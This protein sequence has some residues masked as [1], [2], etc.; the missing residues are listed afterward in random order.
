MKPGMPSTSPKVAVPTMVISVGGVLGEDA[1]GVAEGPALVVHG[2]LV[3]DDLVR[4]PRARGRP[5]RANGLSRSSSIQLTPIVPPRPSPVSARAVGVDQLGEALDR[6]GGGVDAV[7]GLDAGRRADASTRSWTSMPPSPSTPVVR[8]TT[9]SMPSLDVAKS[10]SKVFPMVSVRI[11]VPA[12]KATPRTTARPVSTKRT[13]WAQRPL[14]VRLNMAIY[15]PKLFMRSRTDSA[16]GCVE[17]VDDVAVGEEDDPVGVGRRHGVVGD[18]HDRLAELPHGLAHEGEDLGA[19]AAVEVAGGLVGEDDLRAAGEGA[20]HGHALLLATGELAG[21]VLEAVAEPDG[22]DTTRSS[23]ARSG[24]RPARSIGSVMFS[25]AVSV[26]TRL[27]AWNTKPRR[28]R[29]SFVSFLSFRRGEV[30]V[31][32]EHL[33][34][35]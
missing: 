16:V 10:P 1:D 30:D 32:D 11:I 24:L 19:G 29:R 26:G 31:A 13:L 18:H 2:G 4:R 34:R 7:D 5:T 27:N 15:L 8:C 21:P 9:T 28:S 12:M 17:L 25:R 35:R 3:E 23:H 20:G 6:A 22:V 33:A 14:R